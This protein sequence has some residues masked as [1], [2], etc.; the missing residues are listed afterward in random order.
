MAMRS[1]V[2]AVFKGV[3]MASSDEAAV[4]FP[5]EAAIVD[6]PDEA[7]VGTGSLPCEPFDGPALDGP[8]FDGPAFE[9]ATGAAFCGVGSKGALVGGRGAFAG[10]E[11]GT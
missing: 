10:A 1:G 11:R 7:A 5:D 6:L 8:A 2:T 9:A 3:T 4:D